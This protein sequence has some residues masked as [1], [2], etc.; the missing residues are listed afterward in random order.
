M[1]NRKCVECGNVCNW[2]FFVSIE[3]LSQKNVNFLFILSATKIIFLFSFVGAKIK[4]ILL[5]NFDFWLIWTKKH[6]KHVK[7]AYSLK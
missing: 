2:G 5:T 1:I 7:T 4:I 3:S 6:R